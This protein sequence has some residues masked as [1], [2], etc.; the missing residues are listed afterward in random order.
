[1]DLLSDI[2][3]GLI[4]VE[5]YGTYIRKH[6]KSVIVKSRKVKSIV[7]ENLLLIE[8]KQG[9]G[10]IRLGEPEK[11]SLN[12]FSKMRSK[13]HI[14]E[15][16]R[17]KWWPKYRS[18]YSYPII[19]SK[20]FKIPILL[21]YPTGPQITVLPNNITFKQIFIGMSGYYY[22]QMYPKSVKNILD[23][24]GQYLNSVEINSTFYHY[25]PKSSVV[26]LQKY[27]LT[28]VIKVNQKITHHKKL[29]GVKT[30]W[31][32]FYHSLELIHDK[33]MCFLFQF[34][35]NFH[36]TPETYKS[37]KNLAPILKKK[38]HRYAF[39]FRHAS[40]FNND[41]INKLFSK[42]NWM[43]VIVDVSNKTGWAGDLDDGFNPP[44]ENYQVTS[45]SVYLRMH[46]T[47]DQYIGSYHKKDYRNIF[48]FIDEKQI[49]NA[50][51]YFNNTDRGTDAFDNAIELSNHFNAVNL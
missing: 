17:V 13:H 25:P 8:N 36:F 12:K 34:N 45:D 21:D 29:V 49:V 24:Y 47:V 4:L 43:L 30:L 37:I 19:K 50:F 9:L 1:M 41:K 26:N 7:D 22:R 18:L 2:H 27:D 23:Y 33:I 14:T 40:W 51:V 5:P 46:G 10:I 6:Q 16:D 28:Y 39:E 35:K 3:R 44:L 31:D 38:K 15:D 42:N 48:N 11:I 20:F 32:Q